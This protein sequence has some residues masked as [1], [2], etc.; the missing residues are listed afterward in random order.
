MISLTQDILITKEDI[1][2]TNWQDLIDIVD[3][4]E[5]FSY[6]KVFDNK[7]LEEH[8]N[9]NDKAYFVYSLFGSITSLMLHEPLEE[10]PFG[11]SSLPRYPPQVKLEN[12]SDVHL[13]IL[14]EILPNV[15][16]AEMKARLADV[17][18][19]RKKKVLIAEIAIKAYLSSFENLLDINQ[20]TTSFDRI[21]RAF[22]L[23]KRMG[24][25][26]ELFNKVTETI[27]ITIEQ[28]YEEDDLYLSEQ[29]MNLLINNKLVDNAH[30]YVCISRKLAEKAERKER[31][32]VAKAYWEC[33]ARWY[34]LTKNFAARREILIL[35]A[36]TSVKQSDSIL[37]KPKPIYNLAVVHLQDAIDA[38]KNI[39][40]THDRVGEL[41]RKLLTLQ[42]KSMEE[43]IPVF[44]KPVDISACVAQSI[45]LVKG[46]SFIEKLDVL[47]T[48]KTVPKIAELK[49]RVI[50]SNKKDITTDFFRDIKVSTTGKVIDKQPN[51]KDDKH[52]DINLNNNMFAESK[53]TQI[54]LSRSFITPIQKQILS[55]HPSLTILDILQIVM[56]SPFVPK[57]REEI[58]AKGLYAGLVGDFIISTHLLIP[59]LENSI[60]F[61]LKQNGVITSGHDSKGI[62]EEK[63]LDTLLKTNELSEILTEDLIFCLRGLLIE[64]FGSNL[65]NETAHGLMNSTSFDSSLTQYLWWV[66]FQIVYKDAL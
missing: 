37:S 39:D 54:C 12:L 23:A 5:C 4:K 13:D 60:R 15:F 46:K 10:N 32:E 30:N 36:E 48:S 3:T 59:Q 44:S 52:S 2:K 49:I 47:L 29:L 28:Y 43:M 31:W 53:E 57:G 24:K 62:Q 34:K 65:R 25:G 33:S 40:N 64:R 56:K 42:E 61:A 22:F 8:E 55:E 14:E 11:F 26:K 6:K 7:A 27:R 1:D 19:I 66:I 63:G 16:D 45:Q 20:W 18:W 38:F 17:I 50:E 41:H 51:S 21:A 35:K 58:Y 9:G